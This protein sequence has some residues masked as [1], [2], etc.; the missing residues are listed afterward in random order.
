MMRMILIL[1]VYIAFQ[2]ATYAQAVS[3]PNLVRSTTS[4]SGSSVEIN[5]DNT[6]YVIQQSIGQ[7]STIGTYNASSYILRQ[8]FI[9]P[10]VFA[11]ILDKD[12]PLDLRASVY[13][14]PFIEN[15]ILS[16]SEAITGPV[17]V[18]LFDMSGREIYADDFSGNNRITV[19][20]KNLPQANYI[21]KVRANNKQFIKKVIKN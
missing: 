7:T 21:L 6:N 18:Y 16:F 10:N 13:P 11:K 3:N 9:Q 12:I 19:H 8:G 15:I 2:C 1:C 17:E 4:A 5:V 20:L 14:N